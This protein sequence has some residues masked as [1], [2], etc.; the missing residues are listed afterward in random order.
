MKNILVV[1]G[2]SAGVMSAYTFKKLFPEKNVTILESEDIPTVGVGES[3]LGRINQWI[4]MVGLDEKD[5]IKKCNASLK[6]SIRFENFYKKGDGGFHYPFGAPVFNHPNDW[7]IKKTLYPDT[8]ISDYVNCYYPIMAL[9][10]SNKVSTKNFDGYSYDSDVAYHFDATMFANWLKDEFIKIGGVVE[11]GSIKNFNVN[12]DG[13]ENLI[14]DKEKKYTADLF[15]D[16]TGWKSLLLGNILKEPF[17]SY[18]N[19]LPN[20]KAWAAHLPYTDKEK[21]IKP[22]TNCTALNNGWV[23]NIPLWSRIGTGYVYSDKYVSDEEALKEFKEYL[24]RDDLN[25]KNLT[26]RVGLHKRIF[27]KNVCAIG[28]SAGFIE[29]LESNGLLSVHV[30]LSNLVKIIRDRPIVSNFLKDHF[31]TACHRFFKIFSEFVATH[32]ALSTRDDSEYW[33]DI[34]K[35]NYPIDKVYSRFDSHFQMSNYFNFDNHAYPKFETG[36]SCVGVGMN[37]WPTDE[38][39]LRHD[40]Y[41]NNLEV[42]KDKWSNNIKQMEE[43]KKRWEEQIKDCPTLYQHLKTLHEI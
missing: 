24:G 12:E 43:T 13:I 38:N 3:T 35:R 34:Q 25:F 2:G 6:M 37:F 1:G 27:L 32:Y 26:M 7:F 29:P 8:P 33:R 10:N 9:V 16:C 40:G 11:K 28:L 20:N 23:W 41:E 18:S 15:V 4:K 14:T 42:L 5:F 21:E 19:I 30:F 39:I 22:Y 36:I 31:N 17:E